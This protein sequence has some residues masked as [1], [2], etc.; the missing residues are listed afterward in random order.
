M[1]QAGKVAAADTVNIIFR[2][3]QFRTKVTFRP[4]NYLLTS[5]VLEGLQQLSGQKSF[6][7]LPSGKA[8]TER[9]PLREGI[10]IN[11]ASGAAFARASYAITQKLSRLGIAGLLGIGAFAGATGAQAANTG[12]T[13]VVIQ[14]P[15]NTLAFGG[16]SCG[17]AGTFYL[18][19][20]YAMDTIDPANPLNT[21]I[22]D[23]ALA[24]KD[25][26]GYVDLYFNFAIILPTNPAN[27]T[28]RVISDI[29][30]RSGSTLAQPNEANSPAQSASNCTAAVPTYF[31]S[32]GWAT[33]DMGWEQDG[34]GDPTSTGL[35]YPNLN[36]EFAAAGVNSYLAN[37]TN[38]PKMPIATNGG[39]TITGPGY[40]YIVETNSTTGS[41]NLGGGIAFPNYPAASSNANSV[42]GP[43]ST[44]GS[45]VLTHRQ[46]L[47]DTPTVLPSTDWQFNLGAD[48][49]CDSIS[50]LPGAQT[51]PAYYAACTALQSPTLACFVSA[52]IY[53]LSYTAAQPTVNGTGHALIRD[54]HSWLKGN[55][56]SASQTLNPFVASGTNTIKDIYSWTSS[57]PART[58]NDYLHLG[59][60]GDLNGKRVFDGMNNW[61]GA[62]AGIS[63]NYRWSHTTETERNR[64]QHLWVEQFFPFADVVTTDPISGTTDGRYVKCTANNT[65][66]LMNVEQYSANEYWVKTASLFTTDPT[67]KFD[68]PDSPFSR[69]YYM[70]TLQH[71][72]GTQSSKTSTGVCQNFNNPIDD[73][74]SQRAMFR[75]LD[76]YNVGNIP[77]PPSQIPTL[78]SGTLVS[79]LTMKFPSGFQHSGAGTGTFP[80]LYTGLETTRYR[81]N[82]GAQF[83]SSTTNGAGAPGSPVMIPTINPP[84]I[85]GAFENNPANG[86]IYPSYVPLVNADGNDLTGVAMPE[87]QAPLATYMGWNYRSGGTNNPTGPANDGPDGC[88]STGSY[89]QFA[90]T[91]G[92]AAAG[93]PRPP[94]S[95]RYPTYAAYLNQAIAATDRL[96]WNRQLLCGSDTN[97]TSTVISGTLGSSEVAN[98]INDWNTLVPS[99]PYPASVSPPSQL[100]ACNFAMTHNFNGGNGGI[101]S[102]GGANGGNAS[103]VLFRDGSG[104]IGVW[105]MNGSSISQ[106]TVLGDVPLT[107]S[108]VG[109]RDINGDGNADIIWRDNQ[110][111]VGVWLMNGTSILSSSVLGNV[112]PNWSVA[113]TI[114]FNTGGYGSILW[115]DNAGNLAVW[116]M[117]GTTVVSTATLGNMSLAYAVVGS[118]VHGNV[119]WRN[120]STGDVQIWSLYGTNVTQTVDLGVVPLNWTFAGIGDFAGSGSSSVLWRDNLGNV[121]M[122]L[123]NGTS[124][125]STKVLGNVPLNWTVA[126]TG[127]YNGDGMSDILWVDNLGNVAAWFMNGTSIA[128]VASYGNTGTNWTV[129]ALNSE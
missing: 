120:T 75:A 55:S 79:P 84:V 54:F 39:A 105:L 47:D 104:N 50:L 89:V 63:M 115:R 40:E 90:T 35:T 73:E 103:S 21:G 112:P 15:P 7:T 122:W 64:Q 36:G 2:Q 102:I 42:G 38:V 70:S 52:D 80:V 81:F 88:E 94:I 11:T 56:G 124:I 86:P 53:E 119:Y 46:H 58:L 101:A 18:V 108:I 27:F 113:G 121:G 67:G 100:P 22:T 14:T 123:M 66:P 16:N 57:Q 10:V 76:Q 83:Y 44:G 62:G 126:Q 82:M 6:T 37:S 93:D 128:S 48:G 74:Y 97:P 5:K 20:G 25:T 116:F 98:L 41:F 99:P 28:G 33:T 59:F 110:G 77:M 127:D 125:A 129:Q 24:P 65:C 69:K 106:A 107:W 71:G 43:C 111:N 109:Q 95:T 96:I 51:T 45:N 9:A 19:Q 117:N 114:G 4:V 60:N 78:A 32:Q 72:G 34:G 17:K 12:I 92:T 49:N 29:P 118:D 31:Y 13:Q 3:P 8:V 87:L 85:T 91:P 30:N 1:A 26:N 68:L 23:I 61:I